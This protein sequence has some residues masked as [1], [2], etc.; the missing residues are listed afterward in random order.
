[1]SPK[2][3]PVRGFAEISIVGVL[4]SWFFDRRAR[5]PEI[6]TARPQIGAS[7]W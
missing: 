1:M 5:F 2:R 6:R 3:P 7:R 4:M